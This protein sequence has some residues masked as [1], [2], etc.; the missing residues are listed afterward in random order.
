MKLDAND[1]DEADI[2]ERAFDGVRGSQPG[3][4][5]EATALVHRVERRRRSLARRRAFV[6]TGAATIAAL[7]ALVLVTGQVSSPSGERTDAGFPAVA[8][9]GGDPGEPVAPPDVATELREGIEVTPENRT[10]VLERVAPEFPVPEGQD[11]DF[12]VELLGDARQSMVG[13]RGV[14]GINAA[15]L[16]FEDAA[17]GRELTASEVDVVESIPE[18]PIFGEVSD[19]ATLESLDRVSRAAVAGDVEE[20]TAFTSLN[21]DR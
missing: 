18:W 12:V 15:C 4:L 1:T 10:K 2:V 11:L 17:S 21:C 8:S 9:E 5:L 20:L 3:S 14:V 13:F 19:A 6:R 16:W 7:G